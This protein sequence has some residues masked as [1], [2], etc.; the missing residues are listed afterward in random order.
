MIMNLKK[1][2]PIIGLLIFLVLIIGIGIENIIAAF[3]TADVF[4][5]ASSF[6]VLPFIV[7]VQVVK[8][9]LLIGPNFENINFTSLL[10][11]YL[12]SFFYGAITPG[13]LGSFIRISY[14][15][16]KSN[17]S[18]GSASTSVFLDRFLDFV[19]I[20]AFALFGAFLVASFLTDLIIALIVLT[21]VMIFLLWFFS[22]KNRSKIFFKKFFLAILPEK[23]KEKSMEIFEDFF[24]S[25]PKRNKIYQ[26]GFL[27][28]ISW[29]LIFFHSYIV[30]LAFGITPN[31]FFVIGALA[32]ASVISLIPI[33]I[34]GIG[35][36]E[37]T[38]VLIFS[39]IGISSSVV[40][41][42]S[43]LGQT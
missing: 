17:V 23:L 22:S 25:I 36:N 13:K 40:V 24:N 33:T 7:F 28:L 4:I 21:V 27:S 19:S 3:L 5:L 31:I 16:K 30:I 2:L 18:I 29:F 34:N 43:I 8:W 14:L 11:I 37:A 41:A 1:F 26:S 42:F 9:K 39:L 20:F 32:I 10:K 35:T 15:K 38:L 6:L 12:I